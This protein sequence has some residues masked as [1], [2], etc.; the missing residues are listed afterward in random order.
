MIDQYHYKNLLMIPDNNITWF[1]SLMYSQSLHHYWH[2]MNLYFGWM[3]L[4]HQT[5]SSDMNR[6]KVKRRRSWLWGYYQQCHYKR[7]PWTW[8]LQNLHH[9]WHPMN[10][11]LGWIMVHHQTC[12]TVINSHRSIVVT[13][14]EDDHGSEYIMLLKEF[15]NILDFVISS[16]SVLTKYTP[17]LTS[18]EL[19]SPLNG[20]P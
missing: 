7:Q 1:S 16:F 20:V 17:L 8:Y 3:I 18:H 19:I 13:R 2:P 14:K 4:H 12:P 15:T 6:W 5:C 11:S 10:L 9:Y